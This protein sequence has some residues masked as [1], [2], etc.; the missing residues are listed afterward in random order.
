MK[1]INEI[2]KNQIDVLK[3]MGIGINMFTIKYQSSNNIVYN[4]DFEYEKI[5]YHLAI[6]Y[7]FDKNTISFQISDGKTFKDLKEEVVND[8][9]SENVIKYISKIVFN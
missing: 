1:L 7:N 9:F 5:R 2:E 3:T 4:I 6:C 8:N